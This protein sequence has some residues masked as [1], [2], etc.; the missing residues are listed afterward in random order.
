M[1]VIR[2]HRDGTPWDTELISNP[3][4]EQ[5][6]LAIRRMDNFCFPII[7]LSTR[8]FPTG[9]KVFVDDEAFNIIGG[10]GRFA[11]VHMTGDWRYEDPNGSRAEA[12]LWDSDQGYFC[13]E[14]NVASDIAL[15]C[16]IVKGYFDTGSYESLDAIA[17]GTGT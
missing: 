5:V 1:A 9:D 17:S 11:L 14:R 10:N 3:A 13:E 15:V 6:E 16:R 2:Y 12:R 8:E 7:L 4:W